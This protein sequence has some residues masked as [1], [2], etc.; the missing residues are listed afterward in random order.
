MRAVAVFWI[1]ILGTLT[2]CGT[3]Q[4]KLSA[5]QDAL[6]ADF[7]EKVAVE[8]IEQTTTIPM[9]PKRSDSVDTP[10]Y[11]IEP[12]SPTIDPAE[13]VGTIGGILNLRFAPNAPIS[14]YLFNPE[15]SS[16][17]YWQ[18]WYALTEPTCEDVNQRASH[19]VDDF[20]HLLEKDESS[21]HISSS[22]VF[23]V[24]F[25]DEK[26]DVIS[27]S[28]AKPQNNPLEAICDALF[29]DTSSQGEP[30]L[31][32]SIF[33]H[34]Y[35][36]GHLY[37]R[38]SIYDDHNPCTSWSRPEIGLGVFMMAWPEGGWYGYWT[39]MEPDPEPEIGPKLLP[40]GEL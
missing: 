25:M 12:W 33:E 39:W 2:A 11:L 1:V 13:L 37:D 17:W 10:E 14:D 36:N 3:S 32:I 6:K 5:S 19:L 24:C 30:T 22:A 27:S 7:E 15:D 23:G 34:G 28:V 18:G 20:E 26:N 4:S 21:E 35:R 40:L 31:N 16:R 9:L 8:E 38:T 29:A